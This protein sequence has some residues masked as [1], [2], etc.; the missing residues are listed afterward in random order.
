MVDISDVTLATATVTINVVQIG[1]K[2]MTLSVFKQLPENHETD[3]SQL[4]GIVRYEVKDKH[5]E[6]EALWLVHSSNGKLFR[7]AIDIVLDR[8]FFHA[9]EESTRRIVQLK[10]QIEEAK[11]SI[12]RDQ[13]YGQNHWSIKE[14]EADIIKWEEEI[15]LQDKS[16]KDDK[17]FHDIEVK[18]SARDRQLLKDLPQL[19][20]A[21]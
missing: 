8:V 12:I 14:S 16:A 6:S 4:W 9:Y 1:R 17:K 20:I 15:Q 21:V 3:D 11:L 13:K 19:F 10:K 18:R 2:Q 5:G 7:R